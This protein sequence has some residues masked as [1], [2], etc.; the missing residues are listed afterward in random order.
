MDGERIVF[1]RPGRKGCRERFQIVEG[2][3]VLFGKFFLLREWQLA[4][5]RADLTG[6]RF[7]EVEVHKAMGQRR[8]VYEHA[9]GGVHGR[10]G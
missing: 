2:D 10:Q 4:Q 1:A 7:G 5:E 3:S 9:V 6:E 8:P